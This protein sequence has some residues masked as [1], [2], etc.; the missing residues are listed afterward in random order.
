[1]KAAS[2]CPQMRRRI[3]L[4]DERQDIMEQVMLVLYVPLD[5]PVGMRH[6]VVPAFGVHTVDTIKLEMPA[7]DL[8]G[9]SPDHAPVFV[10]EKASLRGGKDQQRGA[11]MAK[12]QQ[13]H[14]PLE[15]MRKPLV[16][17]TIHGLRDVP[18]QR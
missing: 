14:V 3:L 12:D 7:V 4:L 18:H 9:D 6:T 10:L 13:L 8:V 17:F 16:V 2:G 15:I 11:P 5:A 1:A